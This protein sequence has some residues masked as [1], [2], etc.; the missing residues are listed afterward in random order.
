[1]TVNCGRNAIN[2]VVINKCPAI[3]GYLK[4]KIKGYN[5]F[6]MKYLNHQ[7]KNVL[8]ENRPLIQLGNVFENTGIINKG[9]D[10]CRQISKVIKK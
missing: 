10:M 4:L 7:L 3:N 5:I 9:N 2:R 6:F 8:T 1:M